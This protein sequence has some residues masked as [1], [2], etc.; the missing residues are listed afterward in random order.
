MRRFSSRASISVLLASG[1]GDPLD[2]RDEKRIA[3]EE[4][5]DAKAPLALADHVM[6][7]VGARHIAQ[8]IRLGADPVQIDRHRVVG[9]RFALQ[10]QPD[11]TVQP[12]RGL[13]R[14]DRA[15]PAQRHRQHGA[16]KQHEVAGRDQDQR[17]FGQRRNPGQQLFDGA[18]G[19]RTAALPRCVVRVVVLQAYRTSW[20]NRI[21]HRT[22]V[23]LSAAAA[24]GSHWRDAGPKSRTAPAATRSGARNGRTGSPSA[25]CGRLQFGRQ[26]PLAADDQHARRS[27]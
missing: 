10:H 7:A 27:A 15:L 6:A 2:P 13:R 25:G 21:A 8:Q 19:R 16:G 1:F 4:L 11:R 23:R 3:V 20:V 17:V 14:D 5:D 9:R 26:R 18:G 22:R 12:D 24:S